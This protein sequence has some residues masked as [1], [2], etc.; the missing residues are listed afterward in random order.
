[1]LKMIGKYT[2]NLLL[3]LRYMPTSR[4]CSAVARLRK[5]AISNM[6]QL[7][8]RKSLLQMKVESERVPSF[9]YRHREVTTLGVLKTTSA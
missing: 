6:T 2:P 9:I 8:I 5:C 3:L 7:P 4:F 1:M